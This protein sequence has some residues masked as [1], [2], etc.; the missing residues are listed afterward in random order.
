[1]KDLDLPEI[2]KIRRMHCEDHVTWVAPY[3]QK[4]A[5]IDWLGRGLVASPPIITTDFPA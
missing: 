3:V 5:W 1:M 2:P 4:Q